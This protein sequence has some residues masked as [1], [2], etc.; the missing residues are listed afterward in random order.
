ME[1]KTT[2]IRIKESTKKLLDNFGK[3]PESYDDIILRLL[4]E[5][6]KT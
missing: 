6:Q 1:E 2:T 4:N 5:I 3:K